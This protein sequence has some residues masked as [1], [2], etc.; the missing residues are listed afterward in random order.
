M[1]NPYFQNQQNK[2]A[3]KTIK[4]KRKIQSMELSPVLKLE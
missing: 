2:L 4:T 3:S 1:Y